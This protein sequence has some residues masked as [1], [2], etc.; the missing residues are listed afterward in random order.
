MIKA[1]AARAKG[2]VRRTP[3]LNS[4]TLDRLAGRHVFVKA[5]C[6]QHTGSF[7]LRGAW[8][9]I[10]GL[11]PSEK[12]SGV[13][14]VSSGNHAQGIALATHAHKVR[15]V[16]LMPSDAPA[17]KIENTR[18]LG[19]EV[20]LYDRAQDDRDTLSHQ[21]CAER[22]LTMISPYDHPLV[23]A[24]QGTVGIEIAE[25]ARELGIQAARVLVPCGGGGLTSG[26]ALALQSL[27]PDMIVHP[28]EPSGFDDAIRS[29]NSGKIERN[30]RSSGS[31]CDAILTPSPGKIT[32][33][34]MQRLC[35]PGV[36]V[37]DN[38]CLRAM[39][40]AFSWLKIVIEPGGAVALAA[41]LFHGQS[42]GQDDLIV[43]ASGGNVETA[44]FQRA[45][46]QKI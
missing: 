15:A 42:F 8:S 25:Q 22:G 9:A 4:P 3:L 31:I 5:E 36:A 21:L 19:A 26:I 33:P 24:G 41:A 20:V 29:L 16:I 43:V 44:L 7:K 14:A 34:I 12:S 6:L 1:A 2:R 39:A 27:A 45:L 38:E 18:T 37:T 46:A 32:F 28:C 11:D 35:Q 23:I 13:I 10:S 40:L 30:Q 17:Q